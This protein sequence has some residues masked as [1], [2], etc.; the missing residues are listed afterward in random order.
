MHQLSIQIAMQFE[1]VDALARGC[2]AAGR[3]TTRRC[4]AW[5]V[6]RPDFCGWTGCRGSQRRSCATS[7]QV[8]SFYI[9]IEHLA[10]HCP[11]DDPRRVQP[12]VPQGTNERLGVPMPERGVVDQALSPRRPTGGLCHIGFDGGFVDENQSFQMVGHEGLALGDPDAP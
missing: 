6:Q 8:G 5:R 12:V 4:P 9:E 3:G 11:E 7:V 10:V 1:W 2:T